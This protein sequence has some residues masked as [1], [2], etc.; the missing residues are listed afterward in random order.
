MKANNKY[1]H[2]NCTDVFIEVL[3]VQ[4]FD[5]KRVKVRVAWWNVGTVSSFPL[6]IIETIEIKRQDILSWKVYDK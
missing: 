5:I 3:K 1:K 2:A 6:G 4:Y